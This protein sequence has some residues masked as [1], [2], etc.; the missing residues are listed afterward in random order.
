[1][2]VY[3]TDAIIAEECEFFALA[4]HL[5]ERVGGA[6]FRPPSDDLDTQQRA[7]YVYLA[8]D[9]G[10]SLV[11]G[12]AGAGK[13]RLLRDYADAARTC[14][15]RV[16]GV[17]VAGA[18]ARVLGE[19]AEIA[20]T[21]A[22]QLLADLRRGHDPI[23]ARDLIIVD[24]AGAMGT[25]TARDLLR[26]AVDADARVVIVGDP[27][28]H[29]AVERGAPMRALIERYGAHGMSETRRAQDPWMRDVACD[30]RAGLVSQACDTLRQHGCVAE[31]ATQ[32]QALAALADEYAVAHRH[33]E[34]ALLIATRNAD[35]RAL[36][37]RVR[38]AIRAD[39]LGEERTYDRDSGPIA[40]AVGDCV[41]ARARADL[42]QLA[43]VDSRNTRALPRVRVVNG[44]LLR[45]IAHV[46]SSTVV[47]ERADD[48][49]RVIWPLHEHPEIEHGYA[50]TSYRSQGRT[51]DHV[52]ALAANDLAGAYVDAT[53]A[54]KSVR[55]VYSREEVGE[56][57]AWMARV[58]RDARKT[59]V[60][61]Y[62]PGITEPEIDSPAAAP[63][64][65]TPP[66]MRPRGPSLGL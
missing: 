58:Q 33:G 63:P 16:R 4:K 2:R 21:T 12:I 55:I 59:M 1:M 8:D 29:G 47:L 39:L 46:G 9:K 45:V 18:A 14:G 24:E 31:Y 13:S 40:L 37:A 57:G 38:E 7:A 30:L 15:M 34:S 50:V 26:A 19:E 44:D 48:G 17:A 5:R 27:V 23:T 25:R 20:T 10:L 64:T 51:V 3:S 53:R 56:F 28:Q 60:V 65:Q 35:V 52:F 66:T 11:S 22:A 36:N 42:V 61:D 54:R 6:T 62:E 43:R 49:A 41:V 32:E